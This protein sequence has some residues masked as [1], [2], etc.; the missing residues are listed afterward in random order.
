[1]KKIQCLLILILFSF[2]KVFSIGCLG[3]TA[4]KT[5]S[6]LRYDVSIAKDINTKGPEFAPAIYNGKLL[7]V[8]EQSADLVTGESKDIN[9]FPYLDIFEIGLN[10]I[11]K[12]RKPFDSWLNTSFHE[13]HIA[14]NPDQS[15]I[16]LTHLE[17]IKQKNRDYTNRS[18][19]LIY[20]KD[21]HGW[22]KPIPFKYNN[23]N[24]STGQAS[25]S[26]NGEYLFFS[27]D[28]P[29]GFGGKDLYYCK[30]IG[31]EWSIPVN[32]GAE[33]NTQ[34]DEEYPFIKSDGLL[35][36]AS[37]GHE[38]FGGF[39]IYKARKQ[40]ETWKMSKNLGSTINSKD[41]DFGII[42]KDSVNGFFASNRSTGVGK[43]DIYQ[44]SIVNPWKEISGTILMTDRKDHVAQNAKIYLMDST[45]IILDSTITDS[46]GH[47][48]FK[49]LSSDENY[50]ISVDEDDPGFVN[51][52]RFYLM[53]DDGKISMASMTYNKIKFVF[54]NLPID[55]NTIFNLY[56]DE[57]LALSGG[58]SFYKNGET[59]FIENALII[60]KNSSN[61]II[62]TAKTNEFGT[63]VFTHLLTKQDYEIEIK[64][65]SNTHLTEGTLVV[66]SDKTG[67]HIKTFVVGK[68][69]YK[70]H[71]LSEDSTTLSLMEI[72]D[73]EL[74][75]VA[76]KGR[77]Y[78]DNM[79]PVNGANVKLYSK[80]G[81]EYVSVTDEKGN[82]LFKHLKYD[83][84]ENIEI[85]SAD[86]EISNL[87][88]TDHNG[89][90][91]R[92][93]PKGK[94]GQFAYKFIRADKTYM[95]EVS[96]DDPWLQL[97]DFKKGTSLTVIENI[98]YET[99]SYKF[100]VTGLHVLEKVT[101]ILKN[102]PM[103]SLELT[104]HTDS[105]ADD[106]YNLKLSN[107]RAKYALEFLI[108]KGISKKRL[109]AIGCG[110]SKPLNKCINNIPC[111]DEE[112]S[113]NRRT[114]FKIIL[115][116]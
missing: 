51:K 58:L 99:N 9:G 28:M 24:Y 93:I 8:S 32:L 105:R 19:L 82:F 16:Y 71:I 11:N 10:K 91:I 46:K 14:F 5:G 112:L 36:F 34:N 115:N 75:I 101:T 44:F 81:E 84:I 26:G 54:K 52:V 80:T 79:H 116:K 56:E 38:G 70:F 106:M 72:A 114:E 64:L 2:Y 33:I 57:D 49:N 86:S 31:N 15:I 12:K 25:L 65:D 103:L 73:D 96:V 60:A 76:F 109:V 40:N 13:C 68:D 41:D 47:F 21:K 77:I 74:M 48:Q 87:F 6:G 104:S 110:E 45:G 66:L 53:N 107:Q 27:S 39:D 55:E 22:S 23:E 111:S 29:G 78:D 3:D 113:I 94:N 4:K 108:S 43:E 90:I 1:M 62:D 100:D 30:L 95:G 50:M 97:F 102:N 98:H 42:F 69:P 83:Q 35:F 61:D 7:F 92:K 85:I 88:I 63:F 37:N 17:Y 20:R 18:K 67:K 59:T 89:K